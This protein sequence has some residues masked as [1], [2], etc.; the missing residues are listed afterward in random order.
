MTFSFGGIAA[1][2][3]KLTYNV[4]GSNRLL[5]PLDEVNAQM[6]TLAVDR[7]VRADREVLLKSMIQTKMRSATIPSE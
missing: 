6:D 5:S 3:E 7:I 2:R 1:V 4:F